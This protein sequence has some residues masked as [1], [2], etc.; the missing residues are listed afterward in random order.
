MEVQV[1]YFHKVKHSTLSHI[2]DVTCIKPET[3]GYD[4]QRSLQV[5]IY[6]HG[7]NQDLHVKVIVVNRE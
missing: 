7:Q 4:P 5:C 3:R 6:C 1:V 2:H